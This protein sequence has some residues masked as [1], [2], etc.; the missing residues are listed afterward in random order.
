MVVLL[1]VSDGQGLLV[2]EEALLLGA[3]WLSAEATEIGPHLSHHPPSQ[4]W[5]VHMVTGSVQRKKADVQGFLRPKP[6]FTCHFFHVLCPEQVTRPAP[7]KGWRN[8]FYLLIGEAAQN[9]GYF[10]SL[11]QSLSKV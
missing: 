10:C 3:G 5:L 4:P 7:C 6:E 1:L 9:C 11:P 2:R 8:R